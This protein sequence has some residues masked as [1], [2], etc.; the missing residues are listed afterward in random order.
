M[1]S[2]DRIKEKLKECQEKSSEAVVDSYK[3]EKISKVNRGAIYGWTEAL[4][5]VIGDEE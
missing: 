2:E 3:D 1:K 5:W 4:E